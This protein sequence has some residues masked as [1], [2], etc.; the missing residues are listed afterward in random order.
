MLAKSCLNFSW[1]DCAT[2]QAHFVLAKK[3]SLVWLRCG[4]YD[5]WPG[6][7]LESNHVVAM[8]QCSHVDNPST[9]RKISFAGRLAVAGKE[10]S[11]TN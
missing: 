8:K 7:S 4:H 10:N 6:A 5:N 9:S 2:S 11:A 1:R 3:V